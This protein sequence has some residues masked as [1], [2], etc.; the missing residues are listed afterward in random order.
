MIREGTAAH[1]QA[2][3]AP[4]LQGRCSDRCMLCCDDRHPSDLLRLGHLD[5]NIRLA[6]RQGVDPIT[7][8]KTATYYPARFLDCTTEV[9]SHPGGWPILWSSTI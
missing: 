4:L 8:V 9:R 6:I 1:N 7:A 3:L 2:A 5:Y